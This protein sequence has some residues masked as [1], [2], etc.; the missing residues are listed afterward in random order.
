MSEQKN[1]LDKPKS[2][3]TVAA[4]FVGA[5]AVIAILAI[6]GLLIGSHFI[7]H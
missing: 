2:L 4:W 5:M 1:V 6:A 3:N 7:A